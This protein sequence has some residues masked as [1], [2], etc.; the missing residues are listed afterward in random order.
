VGREHRISKPKLSSCSSFSSTGWFCLYLINTRAAW[1]CQLYLSNNLLVYAIGVSLVIVPAAHALS[2]CASGPCA[3]SLAPHSSAVAF[4]GSISHEISRKDGSVRLPGAKGAQVSCRQVVAVSH[5]AV[6]HI[7]VT[8][9]QH[10]S[11]AKQP[12][13]CYCRT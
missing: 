7:A 2:T 3:L 4:L 8:F 12:R 13:L 11:P 6:S 1:R 9:H 10:L 5:I